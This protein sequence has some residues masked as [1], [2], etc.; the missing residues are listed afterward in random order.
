MG[1]STRWKRGS[2]M[3]PNFLAMWW[4]P[5]S[6][7]GSHYYKLRLD[8]T[9]LTLKQLYKGPPCDLATRRQRNTKY[10]ILI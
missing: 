2:T 4:G 10:T 3:R 6:P 7:R 5:S 1:N 9:V 8:R